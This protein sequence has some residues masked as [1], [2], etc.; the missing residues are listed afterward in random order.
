MDK[1]LVY[2]TYIATTPE[3]LWQA[4]TDE[5]FTQQYWGG[6]RIRSDWQVGSSV[7][8]IDDKGE[9]DWEGEV[10]ESE[11]PYRLGYTSQSPN[12]P[13]LQPTRVL[14]QIEAIG[15]RVKLTLIHEN[16]ETQSVMAMS[17][18]WSAKLFSLK[19]LLEAEEFLVIAA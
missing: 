4:L 12:T 17:Q 19:R 13:D 8:A 11:P 2:V 3:K 18:G 16:L 7:E 1:P 10:L 15:T 5:A 14:F 6:N 9:V